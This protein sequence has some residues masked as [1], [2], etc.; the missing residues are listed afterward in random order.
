[1]KDAFDMM[2]TGKKGKI[3]LG[4]LKNGLQKLGHQIP[5]ADLQ[6]LMEA[7]SILMHFFHLIGFSFNFAR[8]K[9]MYKSSCQYYQNSSLF[10]IF[11][12]F[13]IEGED[14]HYN[15]VF[16]LLCSFLKWLIV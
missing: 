13:S 8:A 2:D 12:Y 4:E 14:K 10:E 15:Q 5:D 16:N 11:R 9:Y 3:N 7:V 1:M 6:I